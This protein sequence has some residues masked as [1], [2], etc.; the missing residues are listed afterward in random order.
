MS[1]LRRIVLIRHGETVGNSS[2]R[3]HGRGDPEL[4]DEGREHARQAGAQ[5]LGECFDAVVAS[6][7]RRSWESARIIAGGASVRIES[8]L[9]EIDFGRWEGLTAEEIEA[10]DPVL[11]REW[12][13][14]E[15]GFRFPEGEARDAFEARVMH[16][17]GRLQESAVRT[18]LLVLH[19]GPIRAIAKNLL[20][21]ARPAS[22][23]ELGGIVSVTRVADGSWIS[24]RRSSNPTRP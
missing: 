13:K 9:R 14:M 23:P 8:E 11:Y 24:G 3:F 16:G 21:A 19:K 17:L 10:S 5:L 12:Q 22:A 20:S 15:P 4:S 7:L 2:V 6:P 18:A 1:K